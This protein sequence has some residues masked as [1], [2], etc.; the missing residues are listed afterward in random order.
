MTSIKYS[1]GNIVERIFK[2]SKRTKRGVYHNRKKDMDKFKQFF[3]EY[4]S[5]TFVK[6][7]NSCT[8]D[9]LV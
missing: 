5:I 4:T 9:N 1:V 6:I 2:F 7:Q 8:Y 3:L